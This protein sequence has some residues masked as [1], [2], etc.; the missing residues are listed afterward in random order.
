PTN[1][2]IVPPANASTAPVMTLA[3][4]TTR[5]VRAMAFKTNYDSTNVDTNTYLFLDAVVQQPSTPPAAGWPSDQH[6]SGEIGKYVRNG[7]EFDYGMDPDI[8]NSTNPAIGGI[9]QVKAALM[10]IPSVCVTLPVA[11]LADATTGIYTHAGGDGFEW[12]REASI[13]MLNDPGT[14]DQGFQENCGLR[15][16]GG[17]SRSSENPKH[18]FRILFRGE[19]GAGK[20]EYPIFKDD[21]K[22]A[23]VFDKFDIQTSQNYSW[24]F[25]GDGSNTFLRELWSRDTQL[26]MNH[27]ATRGRFVHMYLNGIY[28]GLYQI[29]ERAEADFAASYKGGTD[30][31]YDVVKVDTNA[32]YTT[33]PTAGDMNAWTDMWNK[34]RAAHFINTDR[35]PVSPYG[36]ATYTQTQKNEAY[37]KLMGLAADGVTPTADPVLLDAENLIDYM[38]IIFYSGNTDAPLSQFLGNESPNNFYAIRDR[39]GGKGFFSIQHDG[40]HSLN[41]GSAGFDRVGPFNDAI[42][43]TWNTLPKANPQFTHQDL[44]PNAEYRIKF[45][46]R[47]HRHLIAPNGLLTPTRSQ[48]R[49]SSRASVV[50]S[51]IIAESARWGDSKRGA[52][53]PLNANDWRGAAN[54]TLSWFNSRGPQLLTQLRTAGLYPAIDAPVMSQTG[55]LISAS[56]PV[57]LSSSNATIYYSVNGTDPRLIGGALNP[58]AQTYIGGVTNTVTFVTDG[59]SGTQWRYLDNGTDPGTAWRQSGFV[60]TGWK[61]PQAGHLGYGDGDENLPLVGFGPNAAAKYPATYFV[62]TFTGGS[63]AGLT[64]LTLNVKRDDGIIVYLNGTEIVRDNMPAGTVTYQ[65]LASVSAGDDGASFVPFADLPVNLLVS[66]TNTLAVEIHQNSGGSSDISF[67]CRLTATRTTGGSQ[68][69]LPVGVTRLQ[70]RVR[71]ADGTWSALNDQEFL[72]DTQKAVASNLVV[73]EIMYHPSN[74]SPAEIAAGFTSDQDFQWLE[75]QNTGSTPVDLRGAWFAEGIDFLFPDTAGS[76]T[77]IPAGGRVVLVENL[78]AFRQRYGNGLDSL[79]AGEFSGALSNSGERI[80]LK[81]ADGSVI[82]DFTYSDTAPWP[83]DADGAGR[84]LVLELPATHPDPTASGNWRPSAA[85]LGTPGGGDSPG[86]AAWKTANG[87]VS[88][89]ADTDGDGLNSFAEYFHGGNPG[90]SSTDALL[91]SAVVNYPLGVPVV[92]TPLLTFT[93]ERNVAADDTNF[94][95]EHSP[96]LVGGSWTAAPAELLGE[97]MLGSTGRSVVTYR[98]TTPLGSLATRDFF[99]IRAVQR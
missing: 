90:V 7:Q 50:E 32:G 76:A 87:V 20:L 77:L 93:F 66:G 36:A 60:P 18:A 73:S 72:V 45:A 81:A 39:R 12:E 35:S 40:E 23:T 30:D 33:N 15:V 95:F 10:A 57:T 27:P 19:Y 24:S 70:A 62:T 11:S 16:R 6:P 99:R 3:V 5:A 80:L 78:A 26:A 17:F 64:G 22:A 37:F 55:G 92:Q 48:A 96:S 94:T 69:N 13:E 85:L 98:L 89:T 68:I 58:A 8:V 74:A 2:I 25:G 63:L 97:T 83:V 61:G 14:V 82:T 29:Q 86:Y 71:M 52:N 44:A 53:P 4:S 28:W 56:L 75:L 46:D 88:D 21:P 79:I 51:A 31:D 65:T 67:D 91:K 41:A 34:S 1:G 42:S 84:S 43:G 54:A 59:P 38:L 9:P 49:M 47:T